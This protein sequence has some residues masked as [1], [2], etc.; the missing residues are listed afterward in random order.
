MK[1]GQSNTWIGFVSVLQLNQSCIKGFA[2]SSCA[3]DSRKSARE[4]KVVTVQFSWKALKLKFDSGFKPRY[5]NPEVPTVVFISAFHHPS[6]QVTHCLGILSAVTRPPPLFFFLSSYDVH[7][8]RRCSG[9]E[10]WV[11][12]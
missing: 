4:I 6:D 1:S 5:G 9:Q 8:M 2:A 3:Q 10:Q 7:M 12:T 11:S